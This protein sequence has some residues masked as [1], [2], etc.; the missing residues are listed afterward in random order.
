MTEGQLPSTAARQQ[1]SLDHDDEDD[2]EDDDA[3]DGNDDHG[4]KGPWQLLASRCHLMTMMMV[5]KIL[6]MMTTT[7]MSTTMMKTTT[8][9]MKMTTK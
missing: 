6:T 3:D 2:D 8:M 4:D 7:M 9:L 5:H 1:M